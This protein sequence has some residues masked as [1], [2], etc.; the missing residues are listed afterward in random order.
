MRLALKVVMQNYGDFVDII[1]LHL[2]S[3]EWKMNPLE[4]AGTR[5]CVN[6]PQEL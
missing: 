3:S 5:H 6:L 1:L 2:A 4:I